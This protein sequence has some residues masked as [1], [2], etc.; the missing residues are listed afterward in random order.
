M[1]LTHYWFWM[2]HSVGIVDQLPQSSS[3]DSFSY[4]VSLLKEFT[5]RD[6]INAAAA[7]TKS[8]GTLKKRAS[9]WEDKGS[10]NFTMQNAAAVANGMANDDEDRID[11][12]QTM[13]RGKS[14]PSPMGVRARGAGMNRAK[15]VFI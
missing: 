6:E 5:P 9:V 7:E 11:I 12:G 3:Y 2:M 8:I 10:Q 4:H 15:S 1:D 13:H 14:A